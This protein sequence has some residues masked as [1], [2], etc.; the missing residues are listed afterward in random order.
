MGLGS[1]S[2]GDL[3]QVPCHTHA[4]EADFKADKYSYTKCIFMNSGNSNQGMKNTY[5]KAR[6]V[7]VSI[8]EQIF[9]IYTEAGKFWRT[10]E[11]RT[12]KLPCL[13]ERQGIHADAHML[14]TSLSSGCWA[15]GNSSLLHAGEFWNSG[16]KAE[17]W[18]SDWQLEVTSTKWC[19]GCWGYG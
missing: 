4:A 10:I 18:Q 11:T 14:L 16:V 9:M 13:S 8:S 15:A 5:A 1:Q 7:I 2:Q 19:G 12:S 3:S 6:R 17:T